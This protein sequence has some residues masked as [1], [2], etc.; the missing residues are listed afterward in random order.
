MKRIKFNAFHIL[1]LFASLSML[2]SSCNSDDFDPTAQLIKDKQIIKD[3]LAE[4][5]LTAVETASGLHYLE[6]EEGVGD[7]PSPQSKVEVLYKG[8]FTS[9]Q[10]FDQTTGRNTITFSL[11]SVIKGWTEGIQL[12]KRGGKATLFLPSE[13]GYGRNPPSGI[14]ANAVLIF[15]VE[16]VQF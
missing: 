3:Y 1:V 6:V 7:H 8:Y 13:L 2:S 11:Q 9:G 5:N 15:D 10:S 14:P 16:L 12:M 4:K